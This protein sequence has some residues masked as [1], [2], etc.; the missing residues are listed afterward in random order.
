MKSHHCNAL[1]YHQKFNKFIQIID[2]ATEMPQR[3]DWLKYKDDKKMIINF[4]LVFVSFL[5][6]IVTFTD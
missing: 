2:K 3:A 6:F 1:H 5:N 4:Y